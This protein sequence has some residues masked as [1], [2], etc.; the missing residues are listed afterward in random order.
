MNYVKGITW[1]CIA[2]LFMPLSSVA[3]DDQQIKP[4]YLSVQDKNKKIVVASAEAQDKTPAA[5][6]E[7]PV[8]RPPKRGAPAGRIGGGTRGPGREMFVLSVVAPDHT[9]L[10]AVE[11]PS[12]YWFVS[13]LTSSPVEVTVTD[14]QGTHLLLETRIAPP[15]QPGLHRIRLADHGIRLKPGLAY[16]W[17]VAV[18]PDPDRRSKD[19]IAGGAVERVEFPEALRVKLA[20]AG[21]AKAPYIY[22]EAG[23]W[24][25]AVTAISE[26]IDAAPNDKLLHKQRASLLEQVGLTGISE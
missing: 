18:V 9:G 2:G 11:Q 12:L 1:F 15:I 14:P 22:A 19:I 4:V 3:T 6:A 16:R 24:Y 5:A 23:L 20:E 21:K 13:S 17:F 8:Y 26:L 25:D 10:T 7:M